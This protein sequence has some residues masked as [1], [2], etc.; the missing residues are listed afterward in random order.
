MTIRIA[1]WSCSRNVSTAT[2]RS[3]GSRPDTTVVDEPLYAAWLQMT[4]APHPMRE[5]IIAHH[6]SDWRQVVDALCGPQPTPLLYEKHISKHLL[7]E[8]DRSWLASH[9]HAFLI[10]HPHPMLLSFQ[11]KLEKV[12]VEETGLPQQMELWSWLRE[13][14]G[15]SAPVVDAQD[16]L[17]DPEGVLQQLCTALEVPWDPA[18][19]A[20][21]PGLRAT[22]G[23]W[24]S[25]WY[26]AVATSTGF[27]PWSPKRGELGTELREVHDAC[28]PAYRFLAARRIRARGASAEGP[29]SP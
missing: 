24:A 20:W 4:G 8:M 1:M 14:H 23:V 3:W 19:L 15:I 2:M 10:R 16:L 6:P 9:R 22:D 17:S 13:H 21:T 28:L 11:R 18:M 26:D 27:R 25:H 5:E 12:T 29:T 7:P